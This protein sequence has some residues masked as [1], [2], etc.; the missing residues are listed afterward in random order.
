MASREAYDPQTKAAVM[1]A[2]LAGQ[3]MTAIAEEYD[4]PYGT[5]K[6]WKS[7]ELNSGA[8]MSDPDKRMA[9]GELLLEYLQESLVTLT[10]QVR[11]FRNMDWLKEQDASDLAVLHGVQTDKVVRII[12]ALERAQSSD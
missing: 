4:I 1:A 11:H 10:V 9:V 2:L 12:E 3:A 7:R 6:S 8:M 5:V